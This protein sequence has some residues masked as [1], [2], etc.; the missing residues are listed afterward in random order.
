MRFG[1]LDVIWWDW[2]WIPPWVRTS[3]PLSFAYRWCAGIG[4]IELRWW[5][6]KPPQTGGAAR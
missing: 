3:G 1:R 5:R 6:R 4:P 2:R